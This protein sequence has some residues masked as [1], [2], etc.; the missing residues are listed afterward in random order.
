MRVESA[1]EFAELSR[2]NEPR[3][4]E[5]GWHHTE[6][7]RLDVLH[8]GADKVHIALGIDRLNAAGEVYRPFDTLWIAT[9]VDGHWGIQFRSSY[10]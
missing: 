8:A 9:R 10:L 2:A 1:T 4:R 7:R 6:I 5:E 3:L